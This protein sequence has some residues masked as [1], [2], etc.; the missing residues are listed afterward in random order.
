MTSRNSPFQHVRKSCI[1]SDSSKSSDSSD[2]SDS[3]NSRNYSDL[4]DSSDSSES[5][6]SSE[7]SKSSASV[8][9]FLSY[10]ISCSIQHYFNGPLNMK[11]AVNN[12]LGSQFS[13]ISPGNQLLQE[14][15]N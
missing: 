13:Y 8:G 15:A 9:Q 3:S 1:H 14:A 6:E 4:S 5:S 10:F 12:I 11:T 2:S 7:S